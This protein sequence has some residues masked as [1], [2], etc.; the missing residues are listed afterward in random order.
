MS[1]SAN[2]MP[3]FEL[4]QLVEQLTKERDEAREEAKENM[5]RL[6]GCLWLLRDDVR[7]ADIR[8]GG[9]KA[10]ADAEARG[11]ERGKQEAE[12]AGR[13][14]LLPLKREQAQRLMQ[15]AE[16]R[17]YE[18]GLREAAKAAA[19]ANEFTAER[20]LALLE[21]KLSDLPH[22]PELSD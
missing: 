14:I 11:Y 6:V 22:K 12:I 5:H 17:G 9:D 3:D 19:L 18:R 7:I 13:E 8:D 16:A 15:H 2:T 10:L 21:P 4:R 20:I 1:L